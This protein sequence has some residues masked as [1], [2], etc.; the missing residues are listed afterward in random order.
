[1]NFGQHRRQ[2]PVGFFRERVVNVMTAQAR[3]DMPDGNLA[4]V[5]CQRRSKSGGSVALHQHHVGLEPV[6]RIFYRVQYARGEG[7]QR[8]IWTHYIQI[9]VRLDLEK[10]QGVV[11]HAAMLTRMNDCGLKLFRPLPQFVN[12]QRQFDCF[13]SGAEDRDNPTLH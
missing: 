6:T 13:R 1:M 2:P 9:K 10:F 4:V 11:E 5:S 3:F 7:V 8:L 12:H